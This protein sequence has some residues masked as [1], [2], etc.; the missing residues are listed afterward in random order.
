MTAFLIKPATWPDADLAELHRYVEATN[1][2]LAKRHAMADTLESIGAATVATRVR[3]HEGNDGQAFDAEAFTDL[4]RLMAYRIK[5]EHPPLNDFFGQPPQP[6]QM[7]S[8]EMQ[9]K[10]QARIDF[11][12]QYGYSNSV[13]LEE[14]GRFNDNE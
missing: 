10:V 8:E 12:L 2:A 4:Q 3:N 11:A 14:Q 9:A 5:T 13:V 7:S 1:Q 6:A